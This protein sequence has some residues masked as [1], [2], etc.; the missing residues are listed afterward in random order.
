MARSTERTFC[1]NCGSC[2][3]LVLQLEDDR[4][5]EV[6]PDRAHPLTRGYMCIKG[7]MSGE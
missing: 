1:R 4:I 3:G 7:V 5:A 6:T 2:C